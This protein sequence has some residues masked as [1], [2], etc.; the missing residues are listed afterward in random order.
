MANTFRLKRSAVQGKIPSTSDLALGEIGINTYD[1]KVYIKKNDG[2]ESVVEVGNAAQD[3][4]TSKRVID[5]DITIQSGY[6]ALSINDVTVDAGVTV[7]IPS[8]STWVV[9]G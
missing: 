4:I 9:V 3:I 5:S 8:G 2:T 7:T 6:N 1:G